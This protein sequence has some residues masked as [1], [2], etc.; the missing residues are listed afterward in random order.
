MPAVLGSSSHAE[1]WPKQLG[2]INSTP[3]A[4]QQQLGWPSTKGKLLLFDWGGTN[5]AQLKLWTG[6]PPFPAEPRQR[7]EHCPRELQPCESHSHWSSP[8]LFMDFHQFHP[9]PPRPSHADRGHGSSQPLCSSFVCG[10]CGIQPLLCCWKNK[11]KLI[12][13][14]WLWVQNKAK[15][16]GL[17]ALRVSSDD[18]SLPWC[19]RQRC[20][21]GKAQP[22]LV[23]CSPPPP[24]LSST[25]GQGDH[26]VPKITTWII[27]LNCFGHTWGGLNQAR[28]AWCGKAG[29]A[30]TSETPL[31]FC[32]WL[33]LDTHGKKQQKQNHL[34][35]DK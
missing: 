20:S 11:I 6:I 16:L 23:Q 10:G 15:F 26:G 12:K 25:W 8:F 28:R 5:S 13:K 19:H 21:Y 4:G 31:Y 17:V 2:G 9:C 30:Q 27:S 1:P 24:G 33:Q 29:W 22:M 18:F 14:L 3:P 34:I 35:C 32:L 7:G